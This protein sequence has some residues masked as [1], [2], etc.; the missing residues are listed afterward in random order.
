M[1]RA[2]DTRGGLRELREY[3]DTNPRDRAA[4]QRIGTVVYERAR[5]L[6]T[7]G[8]REQARNV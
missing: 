6:E 3:V 4:R 8:T 5:E 7:N 1:F 2:G